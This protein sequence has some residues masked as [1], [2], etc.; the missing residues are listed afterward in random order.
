MWSEFD[1]L[2]SLHHSTR[3]AAIRAA[4]REWVAK[5]RNDALPPVKLVHIEGAPRS[6]SLRKTLPPETP[7]PFPPAS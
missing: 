4:A 1:R 5:H 6:S 2:A 7:D 3:S